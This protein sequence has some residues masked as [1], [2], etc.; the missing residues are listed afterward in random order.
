VRAARGLRHP[1]WPPE[2]RCRSA[3]A[4]AGTPPSLFPPLCPA[5]RF[6]RPLATAV[7]L[8]PSVTRRARADKRAA[9][10]K[11]PV[12]QLASRAA[13]LKLVCPV[14]KARRHPPPQCSARSLSSAAPAASPPLAARCCCCSARLCRSARVDRRRAPAPSL[15]LSAFACR[16][17][18][19][20]G[21]ALQR[22]D[23]AHGVQAPSGA[24]PIGGGG[25]RAQMRGGCVAA[26]AAVP[27]NAPNL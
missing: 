20:T 15:S 5:T 18:A 10:H 21:A 7:A 27:P 14:C 1:P 17:R 25:Q 11:E 23:A 12:S 24:D 8:T 16:C 9:A 26:T 13:C 3:C 4:A 19:D 22:S 6:P 2:L